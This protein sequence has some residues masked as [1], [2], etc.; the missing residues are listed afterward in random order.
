MP[1]PNPGHHFGM[2]M[3]SGEGM[4]VVFK[5]NGEI[6]QAHKFM[7]AARSPIFKAQ[8]FGPM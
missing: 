4:D 1:K 7:L 8:L 5:I 2:L 3:E 6:F